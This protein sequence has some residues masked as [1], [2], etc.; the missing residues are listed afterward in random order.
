MPISASGANVNRSAVKRNSRFHL[1]RR[2]IR[3]RA[4]APV[5]LHDGPFA[6]NEAADVLDFAFEDFDVG[7]RDAVILG[8]DHVAGAEQAQALAEGKMHVQR[9]RRA[10]RIG[11]R[12]KLLEIVRAE[13]ILP[14]RRRGIA[15]VARPRAIVFFEER[16]GDLE[17]FPVQLQDGGSNRSSESSNAPL[18]T[19]T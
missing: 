2:Q 10:R 4:A 15:R 8:D 7:R 17:A 9:N 12:V 6:G 16:F 14:D 19:R 3:R 1:L 5:K 13:I 18:P 11:R